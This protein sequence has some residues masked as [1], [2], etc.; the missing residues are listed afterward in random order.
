MF[1]REAPNG[2]EQSS[3]LDAADAS[4][5]TRK[6]TISDRVVLDTFYYVA[7]NR[8]AHRDLSAF[9]RDSTST[10]RLSWL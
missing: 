1:D 6:H 5:L 9:K 3:P 7:L 10:P 8:R 2:E 4:S